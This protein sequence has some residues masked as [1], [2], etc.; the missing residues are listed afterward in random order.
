MKNIIMVVGHDRLG[1]R[2]HF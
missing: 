2:V 1:Q